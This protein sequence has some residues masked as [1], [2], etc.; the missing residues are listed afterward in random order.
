MNIA[1]ILSPLFYFGKIKLYSPICGECELDRVSDG[2][3]ITVID[4]DGLSLTFYVDGRYRIGSECLLFPSKECRDWSP[5]SWRSIIIPQLVGTVLTSKGSWSWLV[6][7]DGLLPLWPSAGLEMPIVKFEDFNWDNDN[8]VI[9]KDEEIDEYFDYFKERGYEFHNGDVTKKEWS[10]FDAKDGEILYDEDDCTTFIFKEIK[11]DN[12]FRYITLTGE[13][14]VFYIGDDWGSNNCYCN[15]EL[16]SNIRPA[17]ELERGY[18][19]QKINEMGIYW[20]PC[21]KEVYK[22]TGETVHNCTETAHNTVTFSKEDFKPY[23][24]VIVRAYE[25]NDIWVAD[26]FSHIEDDC[27]ITLGGCSWDYCLPFNDDTKYLL[28]TDLSYNGPY[29]TWEN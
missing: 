17:T 16:A 15:I 7:K 6:T 9:A 22:F 29:K 27:Y 2:N 12:I 24:R 13:M 28:G 25:D 8:V 23:D 1:E 26:L 11:N 5:A 21:T 18:F 4:N 14:D 19:Y 20:N 10:I 3:Y